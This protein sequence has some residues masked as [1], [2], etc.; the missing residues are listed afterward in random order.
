MFFIVKSLRGGEM[1]NW[2]DWQVVLVLKKFSRKFQGDGKFEKLGPIDNIVYWHW[3]G[4][5]ASIKVIIIKGG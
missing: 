1:K 5:P 4:Y 2:N 3:K